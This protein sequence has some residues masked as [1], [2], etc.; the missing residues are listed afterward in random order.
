MK[1]DSR[2][3]G[4]FVVGGLAVALTYY[5]GFYKP[6]LDEPNADVPG[7]FVRDV[8]A[9]VADR[10]PTAGDESLVSSTG[11]DAELVD[12]N[13]RAMASYRDEKY[14]QAFKIM[15]DLFE[16]FPEAGE[17]YGLNASRLAGHWA[18]QLED[19]YRHQ[20]AAIVLR[21]ALEWHGDGGAPY[22]LLAKLLLTGAKVD[23][24]RAIVE[25]GMHE[26]ADNH[27][28]IALMA[29][30]SS[31]QGDVERAVVLMTQALNQNPNNEFY[32]NKLLQFE[33]EAKV[34]VNYLSAS[35][36]HFESNFDA[37]N[38]SMV[39]NID[40]L[41]QDLERAWSDIS[42]HLGVSNQRRIVVL[43]LAKEDYQAQAPDWSLGVYDG[44]I[45]IVVDDYPE[46]RPQLLAT[47]KHELT[48]AILHSTGLRIPTFV[49]EGLAQMYEPR[50]VDLVR[51]S[52]LHGEL[53]ELSELEGQWTS[54]QNVEQVQSAY[55]YSLSLCHFVRERYGQNA[56]VLLLENLRNTSFQE[57]W[58]ATF[59]DTLQDSDLLHRKFLNN[60]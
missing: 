1:I 33:T 37:Q 60:I 43:W 48:H 41:Q 47:L 59:G 23:E 20:E 5:F 16:Q 22:V 27:R 36:A 58:T 10:Q 21:Q 13:N 40:D 54:W 12:L 29:D 53:P 18:R 24:A 49:Q 26:F 34:F 28:L 50:N 51:K 2:L 19:L 38:R 57:A 11:L 52:Y 39:R 44:R 31:I 3:L 8:D 17:Q 35:T 30:I 14:E 46:S 45:R 4:R 42:N 9:T 32:A 6:Q 7:T 25:Q 55:A 15:Q 56:F